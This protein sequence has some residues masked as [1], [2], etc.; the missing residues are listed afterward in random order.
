M[1]PSHAIFVRPLIGFLDQMISLMRLIGQPFF[2]YRNPL[3]YKPQFVFEIWK[4]VCLSFDWVPKLI[5]ISFQTMEQKFVQSCDTKVD[6]DACKAS[7]MDR[8]RVGTRNSL[9]NRLGRALK[10]RSCSG[11]NTWI[12]HV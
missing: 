8:P 1:S 6:A 10:T 7:Y 5:Q 3:H 12:V 11:V 2:P 4:A 9:V